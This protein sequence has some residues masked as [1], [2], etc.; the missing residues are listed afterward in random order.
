MALI[1]FGQPVLTIE[2][3]GFKGPGGFL[4]LALFNQ[5]DDFQVL[6]VGQPE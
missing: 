3:M 2:N 5:T 1:A 6:P 4:G